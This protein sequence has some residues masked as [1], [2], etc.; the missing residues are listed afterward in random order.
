[1]RTERLRIE[2]QRRLTAKNAEN[3]KNGG[4]GVKANGNG[5]ERTARR[6]RRERRLRVK[7]ERERL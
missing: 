1:V 6:E 2:R 3:A 7:G 4:Y 5:L